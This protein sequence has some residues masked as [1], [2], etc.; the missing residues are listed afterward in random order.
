ME[1]GVRQFNLFYEKNVNDLP[2]AYFCAND[3]IA[4]GVN[5]AINKLGLRDKMDVRI[6]GFNNIPVSK[7]IHPSLTTIEVF[8]E[9]MGKQAVDLCVDNIKKGNYIP[10]KLVIPTRLKIRK[11]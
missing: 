4:V 7:Y 2:T 8:Q 6:C 3:L 9:E 11:S 5:R 10:K 1:S